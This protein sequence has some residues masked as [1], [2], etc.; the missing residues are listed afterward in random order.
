M[1]SPAARRRQ[2]AVE[3]SSTNS[4]TAAPPLRQSTASPFDGQTLIA[5]LGELFPA[6]FVADQW[7]PHRPLKTGIHRDL[8]D[9]GLLSPDECRAVLRRYVSRRM[10]QVA[11]AAGGPR[12]SLDGEPAGEVTPE[13]MAGGKSL[14]ATIEAKRARRAKVIAAARKAAKEAPREVQ[15]AISVAYAKPAR[16][17]LA[18]LK[19]AARARREADAR[20]P[21]GAE[22]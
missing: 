6:L 14:V 4:N 10:Y 19:A 7:K 1:K 11:L 3:N 13:Q 5:V 2:G 15:S 17:G 16:L 20:A 18:E 21:L 12:Y 9:R 8:V 22:R